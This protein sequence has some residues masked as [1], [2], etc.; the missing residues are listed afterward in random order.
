MVGGAFVTIPGVETAPARRTHAERSATTRTALLDAT[1]E[2]LAELGY[3]G[4]TTAEVVRRAGLSRGAQVHHFPTK[5][6]LI[7]AALDHL[8]EIQC[9]NFTEQFATL[10]PQARTEPV[11]LGVLWSVLESQAYRAMMQLA[12]ASFADD[13]LRES[14][15]EVFRQ[16][17]RTFL[18]TFA[19]TFPDAAARANADVM[20]LFAFRAMGS[21]ALYRELGLGQE[22]EETMAM[23]RMLSEVKTNALRLNPE[24]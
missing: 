2:C 7:A 14:V 18:A 12:V 20:A 22:A 8:A 15:A 13:S 1:I 6:L 17:E 3:A 4:T 23:L 21:A 10:P 19:E 16:L 9:R 5:A 24:T 11:A